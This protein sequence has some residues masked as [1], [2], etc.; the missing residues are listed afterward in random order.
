MGQRSTHLRREIANGLAIGNDNGE[1]I[2]NDYGDDKNKVE[3]RIL[4]LIRIGP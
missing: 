2:V 3:E 4:I 1:K